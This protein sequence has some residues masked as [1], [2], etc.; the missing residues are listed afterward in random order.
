MKLDP[1]QLAKIGDYFTR[2]PEVAAVYLYGSYG[3]DEAKE[4]SDVDLGII[5]REKSQTPFCLPQVVMA[6]E[7]K[8][9]LR[10]EVEVQDLTLCRVDFA[11]RVISEG[12]LIYCGDEEK[13]IS[14]EEKI[15]RE[16]FDLKPALDEYYYYL[17][18][19]AKKGELNVRYL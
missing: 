17:S 12:K 9:I 10:K 6:D 18:Q 15:M 4:D 8:E 1:K 11:H 2:K 14:F 5:L 16:F 7:L 19:M 3:R 13:R